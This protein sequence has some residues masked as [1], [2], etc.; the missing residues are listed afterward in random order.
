MVQFKAE[1]MGVC[2]YFKGSEINMS[3]IMKMEAL[4]SSKM[5]ALSQGAAW[6]NNAEG[7][8]LHS[9]RCENLKSYEIEGFENRANP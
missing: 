4:C 9:H 3:S 5:L 2:C 1:D 6:C 8:H 7:F